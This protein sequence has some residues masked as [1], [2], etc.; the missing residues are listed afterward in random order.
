MSTDVDDPWFFG[1]APTLDQPWL[2]I[3]HDIDGAPMLANPLWSNAGT[4]AA[5]AAALAFVRAEFSTDPTTTPV[6]LNPVTLRYIQASI[7]PRALHP[8]VP[9]DPARAG[10]LRGI[11]PPGSDDIWIFDGTHRCVAAF[12][13]GADVTVRLICSS[14]ADG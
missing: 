13:A 4:D 6:P 7:N 1:P 2:S 14:S 10:V 12:L 8:L 3:A 9:Y 11:C 5:T